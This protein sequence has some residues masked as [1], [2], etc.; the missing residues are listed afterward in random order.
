MAIE[1]RKKNTHTHTHC[2]QQSNACAQRPTGNAPSGEGE[3]GAPASECFGFEITYGDVN[4]RHQLPHAFCS[5][6][7]ETPRH[8]CM[9]TDRLV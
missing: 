4:L 9:Q 8:A 3:T 2:T 1:K 5:L 6:Q 7:S